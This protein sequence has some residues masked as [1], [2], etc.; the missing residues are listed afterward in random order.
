MLKSWDE[1]TELEQAIEIY[2]DMHKDAYG[3]RPRF[4][5][6]NYTLEQF[7]AEF[8][9]MSKIIEQADIERKYNESNAV[10]RFENQLASMMQVG[11]QT[12]EQALKWI[13]DAEQSGGDNDYLAWL[14]GLPYNYFKK[15]T[16]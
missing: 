13:H 7:D 9:T 1:M 3:F 14:L 5:Y 6:S 4:D 11:A 8:K 12:R 15:T 10:K 16:I 2:S